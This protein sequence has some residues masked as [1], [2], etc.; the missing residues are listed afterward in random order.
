MF[1]SG[2]QARYSLL[3]TSVAAATGTTACL[4]GKNVYDNVNVSTAVMLGSVSSAG[5]RKNTTGIS[6]LSWAPRRCSLKQKHE[7][8]LNQAPVCSGVTLKAATA[9]VSVADRLT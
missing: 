3:L 9:A 6:A 4:A 7:I 1:I 5:S 2:D 8:L